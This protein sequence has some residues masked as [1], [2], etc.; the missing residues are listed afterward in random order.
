[1]KIALGLVCSGFSD[2]TLACAI[3]GSVL[4]QSHRFKVYWLG[5]TLSGFGDAF[6]LVALPLLV[7]EATHSIANMGL[8]SAAGVGAQVIT[9]L[10][11]GTIVD[12]ADRRK[13]M[14]ACDLGLAFGLLP[15]D[16]K[17]SKPAPRSTPS[18]LLGRV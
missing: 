7:L 13:L 12:R 1:M 6:A 10:F 17:R 15:V 16:C 14:V 3:S 4:L 11:S 2:L 8:V 9:S 18:G 5:Q